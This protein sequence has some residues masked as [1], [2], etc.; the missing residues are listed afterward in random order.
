[1]SI[2]PKYIACQDYRFSNNLNLNKVASNIDSVLLENFRGQNIVLRGIQ[3]EKH[4]L[5]KDEL[6]Q[7]IVETGS[8][9]YDLDNSNE[10]KVS[11]KDIDLFGLACKVIAPIT[12]PILEG[13]HKYKPKSLERPQYRVDIWMIYDASK[14]ENVE[15][16]HSY[17]DAKARDG[18]VFKNPQKKTEALLGLIVI[19]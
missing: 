16:S 17:Y 3:S 14:L 13:F 10:V 2:K 8:D 1:M 9:R 6:I 7:L 5:P 4:N 19:K 11:D 18:Y 12:L 15:Y